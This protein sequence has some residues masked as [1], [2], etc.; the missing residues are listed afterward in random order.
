MSA[1]G[2]PITRHPLCWPAGR[3]RTRSRTKPKFAAGSFAV[4]RDGLLAELKRLGATG[5]ILSTNVA[6]RQDG[7]PYA[8]QRQPDDPGVAV[9]FVRK[10]RDLCLT[11]DRW[12]KVEENM[13][14]LRRWVEAQRGQ[15]RWV[16]SEMIEAVFSGFAA[17]PAAPTTGGRWWEVLGVLAHASVVTV[18]EAYKALAWKHHP[19]RGGDTAEMQR[20]NI[21]Y[22]EF[23][24]ERGLT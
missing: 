21:A 17:L 8:G 5:V 2:T 3:P 20:I 12:Q 24:Q 1:T 15:E 14:A 18:E 22:T 7:L 23:K 4:A 10:G 19:S 11:C 13:D 9:Y 6:L 16:G